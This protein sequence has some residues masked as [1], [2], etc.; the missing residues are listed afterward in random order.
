MKQMKAAF[1]SGPSEIHGELLVS[2]KP[3]SFLGHV[4][5]ETGMIIDEHSD[6][7]G[8]SLAGKIL[9]YPFGK[10]STGDA[11]RLFRSCYN[12]VG[13]AAIIND[14]PD[15]IQVEG[16][17][18]AKIGVLFG[19]DEKPTEILKSG[20]MVTIKDGVITWE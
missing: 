8:Q 17:L 10:G 11:L 12:G 16:A 20:D 9:V 1:F 19:F 7:Y 5:N 3:I 4:N 15:P 2:H 14:T 13:P 18:L 6:I